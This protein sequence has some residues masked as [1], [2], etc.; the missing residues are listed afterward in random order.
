MNS[1]N[2]EINELYIILS[3]IED[4]RKKRGI[5][6]KL[7][8]LILLLIYGVLAGMKEGVEVEFYVQEHFEYFK[9]II[10]LKSVPSHDTFS[11]ILRM[12]DFE[13][14]A[15]VL[16]EWLNT[17]YPEQIKY[18]NGLKVL[19]IDGK[20]VKAATKKSEGEKPVYLMNAQ[21][22]G[23]SISLY[24]NKIGDKENEIT[25]IPKFLDNFNIKDTI[26]T[27]DAIGC[28]QT[29]IDYITNKGGSFVI[30][31][32]ENQKK[33][34]KAI[35]DEE[36]RLKKENKFDELDQ[37]SKSVKEHGRCEIYRSTMITDTSFIYNEFKNKSF[38]GE[39]ARIGVIEKK[40]IRKEQGEY[41]ETKKT[42]YVITNL[43]TIS[44]E[45][46]QAIK[47]SH[48][49]I[50]AQHWLLDVVLN[51]DRL[52]AREGNATINA[53]ILKRFC[54][55]IKSQSTEFKDRPLKRMF[56]SGC[57]NPDKISKILFIDIANQDSNQ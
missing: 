55:R 38:Y 31:V 54:M 21:Y 43:E 23:G 53:S 42:S 34:Y 22:E 28:N 35:E 50:E 56:V 7:C 47:L 13:N 8:D 30:P 49:N 48:W 27:I 40:T 3:K 33:L 51:E 41:K 46:L 29:I 1:N 5:R 45:N 26:V 18:F 37:A 57:I 25:Y 16:G 39:I 4:P 2:E 9:K 36:N 19:H 24:T 10:G 12:L 32:K 17:Y 52:T 20:A 6:Y 14:L 15:T 44:I 11:R